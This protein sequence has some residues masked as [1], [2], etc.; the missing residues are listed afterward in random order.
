MSILVEVIRPASRLNTSSPAKLTS[1][2][3]HNQKLYLGFSSGDFSIYHVDTTITPDHKPPLIATSFK[4]LND[5]RGFFVDKNSTF[6]HEM[7]FPNIHGDN[8]S[9]NDITIISN[10]SITNRIIFAIT[11]G[12][13]V[14]IFE[15]IGNH[16]NLIQTI[17]E[18]RLF[19]T[20]FNYEINGKKYLSIGVKKKLIILEMVYKTRNLFLFKKIHEI[21][22]KERVRAI[23]SIDLQLGLNLIIGLSNDFL[24]LDLNDDFKVS[25][26]FPDS[27]DLYFFTHSTFSYFGLT[28]SGPLIW[29]LKITDEEYLIIK[30]NQIVHLSYHD[31]NITV[32]ECPIKLSTSPVH[33]SFIHPSYLLVIY[34]KKLEII[35]LLGDLIQKINHQINSSTIPVFINESF[36]FLGANNDLLQ[37]NILLYKQQI[38]QY[39]RFGDDRFKDS[40]S[41]LYLIGLGKAIGFV[42]K[43]DEEDE[44]FSGSRVGKEKSKR[45]MLRDLYRQKGVLLFERY[46]KYHEALVGIFIDWLVS[47]KDVLDLFPSFLR[48]ESYYDGFK[49]DKSRNS[50]KRITIDQLQQVKYNTVTDSGTEAEERQSKNTLVSRMPSTIFGQSKSQDLRKFGKAINNLII[51]LTDQRRIHLNFLNDEEFQWKGV[52]ITP[53]DLY[54]FI[55]PETR[56]EALN[57]I[58]IEI[59]TSLFLCYFYCKPM[60][61]GPL[62]RLPNN[63][64]DSK[65]VNKCLLSSFDKDHHYIKELL[66]FYFGR[67]LHREALQ[68]LYDMSHQDHE[69][70]DDELDDLIRSPDL[71]IQYIQKLGNPQLDLVL[72][73]AQ[74]VLTD[75]GVDPMEN[76]K[77]VFMNDTY[78]CES[79]DNFKVLDFLLEKICNEDL[80][81]RYLEWIIFESD[82][83]DQPNKQH[84]MTKFHTKLCLMYLNILKEHINEP[85]FE[86]HPT[87]QKLYKFLETTSVYEPWTVLRNIPTNEVKLLR[88]TIFIYK[89]LG[90]HDKAIDV[91]YNQLDDLDAAIQYCSD[92]Y[93]ENNQEYGTKLLHKLL[94]DLLMH[95]TEN[96]GAISKLVSTQGSKMNTLAIL[97]SLPPSFPIDKLHQFLCV[98]LRDSKKALTDGR[99]ASQLYK[100]GSVKLEHEL[101]MKQNQS[102]SIESSKNICKICKKRLGYSVFTVLKEDVVH[103]ACYQSVNKKN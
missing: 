61:L 60:L 39:L 10:N 77:L 46:N 71:T 41:D 5:L 103:Y 42:D 97:T 27:P 94:E 17:E 82:F 26:L 37:F 86:S 12:D 20:F 29:T 23:N 51:Y 85:D 32:K 16:L 83:N 3:Y 89:R 56:V 9:V 70:H 25:P 24:L 40:R 87:Y 92:I 15:K 22:F 81:I 93:M 7:T 101:L 99:L 91:F 88:F 54:E 19:Q 63:K 52:D 49:E 11:N 79:Y 57:Q 80:A 72:E 96:I 50:I 38:D 31:S 98:Q 2:H 68:M 30:D 14:R 59:D 90:E 47:Y 74:W 34:N 65:V 35:D 66:D 21:P 18:S 102:Y 8:S 62:L 6:D 36:V 64:C 69:D 75:D 4:S 45:L 1:I 67:K 44:F 13:F 73:F 33:V 28:N 95:Y 100:V 84:I 55:V 53:S 58:A 76:G 78:E 43:I 48:S